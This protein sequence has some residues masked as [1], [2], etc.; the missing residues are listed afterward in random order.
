M[1]RTISDQ[2]YWRFWRPQSVLPSWRQSSIS[3]FADRSAVVMGPTGMNVIVELSSFLLVCIGV[4]IAWN[5]VSQL[6][7]S[8]LQ[9]AVRVISQ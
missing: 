2:T 7:A 8:A 6:L 3:A 1:N 4:Q 5:G 9:A